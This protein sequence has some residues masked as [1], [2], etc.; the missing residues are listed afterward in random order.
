MARLPKERIQ[1]GTILVKKKLETE[2]VDDPTFEY[3]FIVDKFSVNLDYLIDQG[4]QPDVSKEY[5]FMLIIPKN[6]ISDK[7]NEVHRNVGNDISN[8]FI[9][10]FALFSLVMM[11]VISY[12]LMKISFNIT[13][14]IIELF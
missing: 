7:I 2:G 4:T 11:G 1:I 3:L 14:P 8:A 12:L 5:L 13:K 10:P 9:I 6:V